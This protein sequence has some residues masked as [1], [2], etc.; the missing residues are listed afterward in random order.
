MY[1][2]HSDYEA[3]AGSIKNRSGILDLIGD[4]TGSTDDVPQMSIS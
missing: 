2:N 4:N 3:N 1:D